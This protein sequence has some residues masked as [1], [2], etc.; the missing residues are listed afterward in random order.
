MDIKWTSLL[1]FMNYSKAR[2]KQIHTSIPDFIIHFA[3][4]WKITAISVP[5]RCLVGD[6]V[7]DFSVYGYRHVLLSEWSLQADL[8]T[9]AMW[10]GNH[11]HDVII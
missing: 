8:N 9:N 2:Y 10:P 6:V 11:K 4:S 5:L 3:R 1:K 7:L